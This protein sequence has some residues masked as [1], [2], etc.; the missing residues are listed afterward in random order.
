MGLESYDAI[1]FPKVLN[2][3]GYKTLTSVAKL[4]Q[5]KEQDRFQIEVTKA[6]GTIRFKEKFLNLKLDFCHGDKLVL[7]EIG[8]AAAACLYNPNY[9]IQSI[10]NET[11]EKFSKVSF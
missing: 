8:V 6:I 11:Y 4:Q 5:Q 7:H 10:Q 3:L 2:M 9:D 1:D